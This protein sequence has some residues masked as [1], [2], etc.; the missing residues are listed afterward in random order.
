[1]VST[2]VLSRDA[3][4]FAW[5]LD[6]DPLGSSV[7]SEHDRDT[8]QALAASH[9]DLRGRVGSGF[10]D[11][12]GK[13]LLDE[14][15]EPDLSIGKDESVAM[16]KRDSLQVGMHEVE[17]VGSQCTE[18]AIPGDHVSDVRHAPALCGSHRAR[19]SCC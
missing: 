12:G 11:S 15:D 13:P 14:I 2:L 5:T 19:L 16:A 6:D 17:V 10:D 3:Q 9:P 8:N 18:Y 4:R 7:A 1:M